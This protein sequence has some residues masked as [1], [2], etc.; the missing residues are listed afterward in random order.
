MANAPVVVR[1]DVDVWTHPH[2]PVPV[3]VP[4]RADPRASGRRCRTIRDAETYSRVAKRVHEIS[5]ENLD[6]LAL[7]GNEI[8]LDAGCS[9]K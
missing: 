1:P 3:R 7:K 9:A 6:R 2:P 5:A 8:V 4:T